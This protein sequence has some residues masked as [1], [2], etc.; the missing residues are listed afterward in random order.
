MDFDEYQ[1]Q[2]R[3]TAIYP[4]LGKNFVYPVLGLVG[5]SGEVAEKIK[6][7]LRDKNGK[8]GAQEK[9]EIGKELGNVLWYLA[10]VAAE[11]DLSLENVAQTNLAK[12]ASRQ[13]RDKLHDSGDNR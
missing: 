9:T 5:E 10:Q 8:I 3:E 2:S 4:N 1:K 13:T 11:L 7:V 12:L 6:K